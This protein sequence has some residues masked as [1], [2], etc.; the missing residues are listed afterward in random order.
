[1]Y[2]NV[3]LICC[4]SETNILYVNYTWVKKK[5]NKNTEDFCTIDYLDVIIIFWTLCPKGEYIHTF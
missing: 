2:I 3:E 1:M 4:T 5:I